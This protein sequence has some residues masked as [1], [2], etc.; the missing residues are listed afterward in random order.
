V[1]DDDTQ[2]WKAFFVA[3]WDRFENEQVAA[4]DICSLVL[5]PKDALSQTVDQTFLDALPEPFLVNRDR[6]EGSL[7]RSI[8][9]HLSRLTGR[10]FNGRKLRDAGTDGHKHVRKWKLEPVVTTDGSPAPGGEW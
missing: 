1:Q 9:R 6:G 10:I 4:S 7:K 3:W 2:Q 8:G 5:P